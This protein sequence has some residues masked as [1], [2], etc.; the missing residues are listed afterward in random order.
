MLSKSFAEAKYRAMNSVTCE[1]MWILKILDELNIDVSLPVHMNCN[2]SSTIQIAANPIFHERKK[3]FEIDLFFLREKVAD[4]VVK[5]VKV[6]SIDNNADIFTKGL[7]VRYHNKFWDD[8]RTYDLYRVGLTRTI[9][10]TKPTFI[11]G[12]NNEMHT[13]VQV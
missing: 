4:S 13:K 2:N 3:H 8:L 11:S 1:V 10:N 6:K 5:T 7:T 9:K 12:T